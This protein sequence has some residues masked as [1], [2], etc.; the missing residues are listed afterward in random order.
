MATGAGTDCKGDEAT[1]CADENVLYHDYDGS[2]RGIYICQDSFNC[3]LKIG[4][5]YYM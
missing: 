5:F 3:T 2:Y 1:F 4:T